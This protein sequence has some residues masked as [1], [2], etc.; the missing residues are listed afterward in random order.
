MKKS[1]ILVGIGILAVVALGVWTFW[2][3][4]QTQKD[5]ITL[6]TI[7]SDAK[8][9]NYIAKQPAT[10]RAHLKV[11]VKSFTDGVALNTATAQGKIDVNAF[12]S[13]AYLQAYNHKNP[14][15][16]LSIIGTTYLEPLGIYSTKYKKLGQ[17]PDG[18]TIAIA[19]NPANTARGLKLLAK[20]GLITLKPNFSDLSG[21][22]GIQ[23]NPHQFKFQEI[24]DTTGPR[25]IKDQKV[26]AAL[27]SNTIALE[28]HLNVLK[29]SLA[30][31]QVNQSTKANINVLATAQTASKQQRQK[32][33]KLLQIYHSKPVQKYI[34][35]E[36]DG[37][38]IEVQKPV[39]YLRK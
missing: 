11:Q 15:N 3:H 20:V 38:K 25:V 34:R 10:K 5:E 37:T 26:A 21:L 16:Q 31:E 19:D 22:N 29:D 36:F 32:Y 8:I 18:S 14:R 4:A 28:G 35:H 30:H 24:D 1:K 7:G 33:Q 9:W 27:I 12:Q 17:I 6:G 39:S 2:G 23:S 13:D